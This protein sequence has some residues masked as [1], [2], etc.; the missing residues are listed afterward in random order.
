VRRTTD[1]EG[2]PVCRRWLLRGGSVEQP[3]ADALW[4]RTSPAF[5]PGAARRGTRHLPPGPRSSHL[6]LLPGEASEADL[7]AG[8]EPALWLPEASRGAL[9]PLS[10]QLALDFPAGRRLRRGA[11]GEPVGPCRLRGRLAD[12]L[13]RVV[14]VGREVRPAGAGWCAKGGQ[15]LPVWATVPALRL[16]DVEV[17]A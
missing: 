3:I 4:A 7:L 6:E 10:G 2:S 1:D 17:S 12:L 15:K 8:G 14:A 9:D 5:L 16:E 13:A 11:L